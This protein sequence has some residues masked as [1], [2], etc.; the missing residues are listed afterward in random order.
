MLRIN[1][2]LKTLE[3]SHEN[4]ITANIHLELNGKQF[5][6]K[7]WKDLPALLLI[8]WLD[9]IELME[10]SDDGEFRF[11]EGA[12]HFT[13]TH[14]KSCFYMTAFQNERQV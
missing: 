8:Y 6:E 2:D 11:I 4:T 7:E 1:C 13:I 5:P 14:D 3:R 9:E 12:F 10:L